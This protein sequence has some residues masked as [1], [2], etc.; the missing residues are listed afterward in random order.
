MEI[1][2]LFAV[3]FVTGEISGFIASYLILKDAIKKGDFKDDE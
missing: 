3:A 2:I 1:L